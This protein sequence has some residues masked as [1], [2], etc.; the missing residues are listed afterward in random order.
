[1]N[2]R[3]GVRSGVSC[4]RRAAGGSVLI[5]VSG[6]KRLGRQSNPYSRGGGR[7]WAGIAYQSCI[8]RWG[9]SG[10]RIPPPHVGTRD[11]S[12]SS[13]AC[14]L[15]HMPKITQITA[16]L[17]NKPGTLAQLCSTLRDAG[18][19]IS[20]VAASE[21]RGRGKVRLLVGRQRLSWYR[22]SILHPP[23]RPARD[24]NPTPVCRNARCV[25]K[26]GWLL[27]GS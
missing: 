18:V 1:M 12:L 10:I 3:L 26:F 6:P 2:E 4:H 22:L 23:L 11:V 15:L 27:T 20:A 13:G 5:P 25:L 8:P 16:T 17:Q 7:D 14:L 24:S 9:L 21:I 19:N